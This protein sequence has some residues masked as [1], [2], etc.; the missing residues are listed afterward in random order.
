MRWPDYSGN[1][2]F[3]SLGNLEVNVRCGIKFIDFMTHDVLQLS[4]T[5]VVDFNDRTLLGAQRV[6]A[7]T[8]HRWRHVVN[9]LPLAPSPIIE[10]NCPLF[11]LVRLIQHY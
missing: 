9:A 11:Y 7:F 5:A 4:G 2:M 10:L 8:V 1:N 3:M 6:V